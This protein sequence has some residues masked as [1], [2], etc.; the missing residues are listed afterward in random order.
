MK[1][2]WLVGLL[3]LAACTVATSAFAQAVAKGQNE[4]NGDVFIIT[5]KPSEDGAERFTRKEFNLSYARLVTD[6]LAVG[7]R[8]GVVQT[9]DQDTSGHLG[10]QARYYFANLSGRAIPFAEVNTNRTFGVP[11]ANDTDL[12]VLAG[13]MF[14]IGNTGG[15]IRVNPYYYRIFFDE[16]KVGYSN[17]QAFGISWSVGLRF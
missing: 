12:T 5:T 15:R 10:V 16:D 7:P 3:A 8:V 2:M 13:L 4:V 9:S 17:F 6:R 14:P 11:V 1:R